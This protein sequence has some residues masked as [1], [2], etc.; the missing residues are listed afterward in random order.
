MVTEADLNWKLE[1]NGIKVPF[2]IPTLPVAFNLS[3]YKTLEPLGPAEPVPNTVV[4]IVPVLDP[5]GRNV[6]AACIKPTPGV[7]VSKKSIAFCFAVV[8]SNTAK[9]AVK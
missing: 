8:E 7:L 5:E 4:V 9:L 2:P 3:K 1:F 6:K